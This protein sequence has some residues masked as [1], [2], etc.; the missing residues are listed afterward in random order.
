[1]RERRAIGAS[2]SECSGG[3]RGSKDGARSDVK[4]KFKN[5][6]YAKAKFESEKRKAPPF[7]TQRMGHPGLHT[8]QPD[9]GA[10]PPA[11]A[12]TARIGQRDRKERGTE[13]Y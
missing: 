8:A 7:A 10:M 5:A 12:E 3:K 11:F 4:R 1:M 13:D 9:G 2:D 6:A